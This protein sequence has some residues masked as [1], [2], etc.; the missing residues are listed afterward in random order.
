[1]KQGKVLM[2]VRI[3]ECHNIQRNID[4]T[5]A[6][7][8]TS[9][10]VREAPRAAR[11]KDTIFPIKAAKRLQNAQSSGEREG[12]GANRCSIHKR[13]WHVLFLD[14]R[15]LATKKQQCSK[16]MRASY[17][18]EQRRSRGSEPGPRQPIRGYR[19][20]ARAIP[21]RL[22]QPKGEAT[23]RQAEPELLGGQWP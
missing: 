23:A 4:A 14:L 8:P 19:N 2:Q 20:G 11:T 12:E 9:I 1:M 18:Q 7:P 10:W 17:M 3:K 6:S 15:R 5:A 21:G 22:S 13:W 16:D